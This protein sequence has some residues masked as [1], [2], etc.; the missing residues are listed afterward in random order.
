MK[1]TTDEGAT[2]LETLWKN[3]FPDGPIPNVSIASN[4]TGSFT[5][6]GT[7][8]SQLKTVASSTVFSLTD[9][10]TA[11]YTAT[12]SVV[13]ASGSG[14]IIS[15]NGTGGIM[16]CTWQTNPVLV[17]VQTIG[18]IGYALKT[19]PA[20][21]I[22]E[23]VGRAVLST[24]QGMAQAVLLGAPF[25][26]DRGGGGPW[27]MQSGSPP[28]STM[29][30]MLLADGTRASLTGFN[31]VY[32]LKDALIGGIT[33]C[34]SNNRTI[35]IHWKLGNEHQL[36]WIACVFTVGIALYGL[37]LV[38]RLRRSRRAHRVDPLRVDDTFLLGVNNAIDF[39]VP[40]PTSQVLQL[41][42]GVVV[43]RY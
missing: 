38:W 41:R 5:Y 15:V 17:Y 3:V 24:L 21:S 12:Y 16:G 18:Y 27:T 42:R 35:A 8:N 33:E 43:T 39:T 20:T 37:V 26:M 34:K 13:N 9:L 31:S 1:C 23:S 14:G 22:P 4:G 25:D 29:L 2:P 19:K 30:Q 11:L 36:G 40:H 28:T 32:Q 7:T 6:N 10:N